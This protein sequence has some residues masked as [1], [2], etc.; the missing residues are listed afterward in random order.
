MIDDPA[1]GETYMVY[2]AW[3]PGHVNGPGDGRL[4]LVD[5]VTWGAGPTL[6]VAPSAV[7]LPTPGS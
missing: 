1:D 6:P 4:L 2:H 7:S 5:L 3:L